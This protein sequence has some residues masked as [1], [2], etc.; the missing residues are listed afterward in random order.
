VGVLDLAVGRHQ[1]TR[2]ALGLIFLGIS[3]AVAAPVT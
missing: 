2:G 1:G 3:S